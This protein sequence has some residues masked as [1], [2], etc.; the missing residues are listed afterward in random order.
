MKQSDIMAEVWR[1]D[2]LECVHRGHYVVSNA[3]GDMLA[4]WGNPNLVI[5]PRSSCK[6]LQALPLL[7]S[8]AA[9]H[10]GLKAKHLAL[11]C[12]SHQGAVMH[13][14]CVKNWLNTIGLSEHNLRCGGHPPHDRDAF[15]GLIRTHQSFDQTHNN[16]SGKHAGFLTL[17]A[18]IGGG[19]DYIDPDH[20]VQLAVKNVLEEMTDETL[21]GHAIDGCS[22]PNFAMTLKG[23]ARAMAS[24]ADP[25]AFGPTRRS[26]AQDL[27]QAMI[28]HPEWVAGK[29]RACTELM[30]AMQ[31]K[32][33][34]KTGAE[35]VF[36]AILPERGL[37]VALKI[38]DGATR[39]SEC[40][41]TALLVR[42]GVADPSHPII[43]KRLFADLRNCRDM[44]VGGIRPSEA[45][46][47]NGAAI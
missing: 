39:A 23:L 2:F 27:V 10:F 25:S 13:T 14:D 6:M 8:G 47:Q 46:Y 28:T 34:V 19:P 31:G 21:Q 4:I 11:A 7:E 29:T 20:P 45:V 40:A 33:A 22:A 9:V 42:L 15:D 30:Q 17:N 37:G 12:A 16:C 35:G 38:E 44:R 32:A 36:T 3:A 5:L 26:A 41:I 43:K 1:G 18:H 24:M